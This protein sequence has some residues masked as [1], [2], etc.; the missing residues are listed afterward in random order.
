MK[1]LLTITL[2]SLCTLS[3]VAQV[4][5]NGFVRSYLGALTGQNG[6][7]AVSQN[8]LDW[9]LSYGKSEVRLFANPIFQYDA[10][11]SEVDLSLR[12][13]YLDI[14]FADFDLRVG[15]QQII[16]GK[17]DGV[18]ITDIISPRDLSE[19]LM[20]DFE[21]IRIGVNAFKLNYYLDNS[22][23][24]AVWIPIFQPT[25]QA[26]V[27]SI[28]APQMPAYPFAVNLDESAMKVEDRL[29]NSEIALKYSA[30]GSVIDYELMAAYLWDDNPAMHIFMQM[31][32]SLLLKPEYHR[33][34][35]AGAS[36]G[37]PVGGAV[38]RGEA[39]YYLG[40]MFSSEDLS[41]NG[42]KEKD[43][44]HYL[45]GYDHNWFG[46]NTS[47]QLI[48]EFILDY[49][50]KIRNDELSSTLTFLA[51]KEFLRDTLRLELLTYYGINNSDAL[52]RPKIMYDL[53]DGFEILLGANV[54]LGDEGNL[55]QYSQNDMLYLKLRYD[56]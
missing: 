19:F 22:T 45:F 46:V 35:M 25:I 33:L 17:A 53:A 6:D 23:L 42:I 44:L 52:L 48:Q 26:E 3:A 55:G 40:K 34:P 36:F 12:Q 27:N 30:L 47:V 8:T 20:P 16:W 39:A 13:A 56:F 2:M 9:R 11:K 31:D 28:W 18:F 32:N 41:S 38:I 21:E 49:E 37:K 1:R 24:E 14:Y 50:D 10:L 29:S 54:F 51:S 7:Y 4:D 43:Y 5:H 15:K